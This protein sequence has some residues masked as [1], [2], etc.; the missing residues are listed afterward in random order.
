[1]DLRDEQKEK[2]EIVD[3]AYMHKFVFDGE[4][5][6]SPDFMSSG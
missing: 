2:S 6:G 3:V 1:M 5:I 4:E